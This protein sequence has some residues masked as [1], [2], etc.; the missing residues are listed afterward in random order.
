MLVLSLPSNPLFISFRSM[1]GE[2][3]ETEPACLRTRMIGPNMRFLLKYLNL[4]YMA[5]SKEP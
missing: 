1:R 2:H 3:G 5:V 4:L